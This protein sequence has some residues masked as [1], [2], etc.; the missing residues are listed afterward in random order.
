MSKYQ[1]DFFFIILVLNFNYV[2]CSDNKKYSYCFNYQDVFV[3]LLFE[4][5]DFFFFFFFILNIFEAFLPL[6]NYRV[7]F[8]SFIYTSETDNYIVH[9]TTYLRTIMSNEWSCLVTP[10]FLFFL[11]FTHQLHANRQL[12]RT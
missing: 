5:S 4:G 12:Y 8:F 2:F 7:F 3:L 9:S 1:D 6:T 11:L 10:I